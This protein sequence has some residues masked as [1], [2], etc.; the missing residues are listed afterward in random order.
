MNA[1]FYA[2]VCMVLRFHV[3]ACDFENA[4]NLGRQMKMI[5]VFP[6]SGAENWDPFNI[7][8]LYVMS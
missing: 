3:F 4:I 7:S 6:F 8:A 2:L 5:N 1:L